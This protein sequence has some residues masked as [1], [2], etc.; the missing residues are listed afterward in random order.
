MMSGFGGLLDI[1]A[2]VGDVDLLF[3]SGSRPLCDLMVQQPQWSPQ[4]LSEAA[5]QFC[6]VRA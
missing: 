3:F 2:L 4:A 1:S 5:G 6:D